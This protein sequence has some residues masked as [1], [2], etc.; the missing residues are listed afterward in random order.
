MARGATGK[1]D[2]FLLGKFRVGDPRNPCWL[3]LPAQRLVAFLA[4][5]PGPQRREQVAEILWPG[6]PSGIARVNLRQ[7][8][9]G[10]RH[11]GCELIQVAHNELW[12]TSDV[13]VD[14]H[15]GTGIAH[16]LLR[17]KDA[18]D[19]LDLDQSDLLE[20]LLPHWGE[21][22]LEQEN[23]RFHSLRVH[24]LEVVGERHLECGRWAAAIQASMLA[25]AADPLREHPRLLLI[26]ALVGEGNRA[27][28]RREYGA[29][30]QLLRRELGDLPSPDLWNLINF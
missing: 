9:Y 17:S 11:S 4:V 24:A 19:N 5:H 23:A 13:T 7:A 6:R 29:Y 25:V 14:L 12:L 15:R 18:A 8:I 22:W 2:L 30:R 21:E 16:R 1:A 20:D 3:P 26:R 27:A 10:E 28:A